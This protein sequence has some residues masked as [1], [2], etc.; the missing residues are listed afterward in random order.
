MQVPTYASKGPCHWNL[1]GYIPYGCFLL[2]LFSQLRREGMKLF[3]IWYQ[4]LMDNATE[5]CHR[6]YKGLVPKLGTEE[7]MDL[8]IFTVRTFPDSES[9]DH[10]SRPPLQ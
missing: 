7:N 2:L 4:I 5:E 6:T 1:L 10:W 9:L 8:D 3:L